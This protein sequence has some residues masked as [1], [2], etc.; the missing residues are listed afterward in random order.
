VVRICKHEDRSK[1]EKRNTIAM[2]LKLFFIALMFFTLTS[3][4]RT[5]EKNSIV[6]VPKIRPTMY[7]IPVHENNAYN[8]AQAE[9]LKYKIR[10]QQERDTIRTIL[11]QK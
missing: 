10:I 7:I 4:N 5:E 2:H 8:K 6:M 1:T 11:D 3:A 9:I